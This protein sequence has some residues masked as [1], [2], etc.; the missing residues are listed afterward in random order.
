[1]KKF[2]EEYRDKHWVKCRFGCDPRNCGSEGRE[3]DCVLKNVVCQMVT[4]QSSAVTLSQPYSRFDNPFLC[5]CER[6]G[7]PC[8]AR[9][10]E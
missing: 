5:F 4:N 1:M 10:K 8:D 3:T 9:W 2:T 6:D 7:D